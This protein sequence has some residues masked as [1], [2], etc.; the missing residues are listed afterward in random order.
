M[1][2]N[3]ETP[4]SATVLDEALYEKYIR[5]TQR[6]RSSLVGVEFELPVVNLNGH[7]VSF[8]TVHEMTE[9]FLRR[10]P[11]DT[12]HRDDEGEIYAA[13]R[14][15]NGDTLSYDCSYNTLELSF[16]TEGDM[17]TI[18]DRFR[19]YYT[20]IQS[21]LQQSGHSLTGMGINPHYRVNRNEPV[22]NGRYRMLLHHLKSYR[23]YGHSIPFHHHPNFGLFSCASQVQLDVDEKTLP[24]VLNTF[25]KLEPLKSL[26]FANS[27][28]G[29][30]NEVLCGRDYFWKN[31]LHGLNRHN[32]DMYSVDFS[33]SDEIISYIKSMSIYCV[34]REGQYINFR[35]T[36]LE[37][38]FS[39]G[40]VEGEFYAEGGYRSIR[41]EPSIEDLKYLRSFKFEDLTYRGTVEFRSVC[42]QPVRDVM[43]SAAFHAGLMEKLPALSDL[44]DG[45]RALYHRGYNA[46]ELRCLLNRREFP[47]FLRKSEITA[48]AFNV[49]DIASDGLRARGLHEEGYLAPLYQRAET[50]TSP[51]LRMAEELENGR[52]LGELIAD[53]AA[54]S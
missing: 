6:P 42:T 35:P 25:T 41:F 11:F 32:V 9:E 54:L 51:A 1:A 22:P 27:P 45:D 52:P 17:H 4:M 34:E 43:A 31:S 26:L 48:L 15:G 21:M 46:S 12:L 14:S 23:R 53:Y 5:P 47:H 10:F 40:S 20:V 13:V 29:R 39:A 49:L 37:D 33:S 3:H 44:L 18:E 50:L 24:E 8:R 36:L 16:G 38:Y 30:R 2:N 28:W 19:A 7:A